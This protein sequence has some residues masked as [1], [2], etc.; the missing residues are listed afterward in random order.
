MSSQ[1]SFNNFPR[2]AVAL[3]KGGGAIVRKAAYDISSN[4]KTNVRVDTG[5][6]KNSISAQ[7]ASSDLHWI[8]SA[9]AEYAIYQEYG[10]NPETEPKWG[11]APFMRPAY[12]KVRPH[13]FAAWRTLINRAAGGGSLS[14]I[15]F[16]RPASDE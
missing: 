2:I 3:Q 1:R 11:F 8:V 5:N 16:N 13:F 4:A 12:Q 10:P 14:D 6:L 15:G 9:H 7:K